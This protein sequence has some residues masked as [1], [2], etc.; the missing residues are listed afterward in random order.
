MNPF[1]IILVVALGLIYII[2]PVDIL[3]DFFPLAGRIDDLGLVAL[4]IYYLKTGRMP[5]FISKLGRWIFGFGSPGHG[6]SEGQ[7]YSGYQDQNAGSRQTG[8]KDP[9]SVL[10]LSPGAS[11]QEIHDAYRRLAHKY[12]PD[13]V[14]HLGEDFQ[15][16]ARQRFLEIQQA[17]EMLAGKDT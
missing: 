4:L 14:S 11:K 3:P 5:L 17:Y 1:W 15:E 8:K 13:K 12:H 6:N 7:S 10:G 16:L 9:Y 2:S